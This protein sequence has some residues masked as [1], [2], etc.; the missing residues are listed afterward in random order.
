M[1]ASETDQPKSASLALTF[2]PHNRLSIGDH[3]GEAAPTRRVGVNNLLEEWVPRVYR[4]ALRL[5][6]DHHVAEDLAQETLLR[7]WRQLGQMRDTRALQVWLFR[8][9]A[10]LWNDQ[11]RRRKSPVGAAG[12]LDEPHL[13]RSHPP[14]RLAADR[15]ELDLALSVMAALPDRQ[16]EVLYLSTCEGLSSTEIG[17][18]L[19]INAAAAKAN[20]SLARQKM[21]EQMPNVF[22]NSTTLEQ[23]GK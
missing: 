2:S 4:F 22:P 10:N 12:P 16:R 18:V 23:N 20:L 14:D 19:G 7:A 17:E 8:I 9:T 6:N 5:C 13:G 1:A 3:R 21:R 11:L 15:E